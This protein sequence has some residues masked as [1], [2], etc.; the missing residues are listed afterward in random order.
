MVSRSGGG[1]TDA[2]PAGGGATAVPALRNVRMNGLSCALSVLVLG[3]ETR[4]EPA[5]LDGCGMRSA[6]FNIIS[7]P[8]RDRRGFHG[9]LWTQ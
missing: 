8:Q 2:D 1:G 9:F 7:A 3:R 4:G 6:K 5:V